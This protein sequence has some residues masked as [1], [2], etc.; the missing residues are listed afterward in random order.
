MYSLRH[1]VSYTIIYISSY[2][3][4]KINIK[5]ATIS[6]YKLKKPDDE[7]IKNY[8]TIHNASSYLNLFYVCFAIYYFLL[9]NLT[10]T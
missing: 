5:K 6:F 9:N 8:Y 4:L 7:I 10:F 1:P 2:Y 3:L